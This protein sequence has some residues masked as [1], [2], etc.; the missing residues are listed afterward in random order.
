MSTSS[1]IPPKCPQSDR[2]KYDLGSYQSSE[3]LPYYT[4]L[5][6]FISL[7][8]RG[9]KEKSNAKMPVACYPLLISTMVGGIYLQ[10]PALNSTYY[11]ATDRLFFIYFPKYY[12]A[13]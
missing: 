9:N 11:K 4:L 10:S 5:N 8:K 6:S 7:R 2:F 1:L 13:M 3:I 12:I